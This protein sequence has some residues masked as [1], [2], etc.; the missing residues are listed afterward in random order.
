MAKCRAMDGSCYN[1]SFICKICCYA[2][3][4]LGNAALECSRVVT[5]TVLFLL[6]CEFCLRIV[7]YD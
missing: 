7:L 4:V 3:F 1:A 2:C 6:C 5:K